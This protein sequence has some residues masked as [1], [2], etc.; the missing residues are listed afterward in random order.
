MEARGDVSRVIHS[1][2]T[3]KAFERRPISGLPVWLRPD[4]ALARVGPRTLA[5]GSGPEVEQLAQ[6]RLG[7][8]PDLKTAG[9]LF[10]RFQALN[11]ASAIRLV[12]RDPSKL[13]GLFHPIFTRELL[14]ASRIAW[15]VAQSSE[16]SQGAS[17]PQDEISAGGYGD[18]RAD[19]ERTAALAS[20]AGF[21]SPPLY[22]GAGSRG[23]RAPISSCASMFRRRALRLLLQRIAKADA[24]AR[25]GSEL[26]QAP[27]DLLTTLFV[28]IR[29]L[30]RQTIRGA[31]VLTFFSSI[32][33][34]AAEV[35]AGSDSEFVDI[36]SV[37]PTILVE[38]RY[39]TPNNFTRR[40]LYRADMP[41]MV[42]LSVAR[43]LAVA[44]KFLE[45]R[46]YGLKIWDAYRPKA[47]QDTTLEGNRQ[48]R[49]CGRP[50]R[51]HRVDAHPR[52]S[53]GRDAGGS[54]RAE[55]FP[56]RLNSIISRRPR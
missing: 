49:L 19:S 47:A 5:V 41:A 11:Q 35:A 42:R 22:P 37:D 51:R 38:L 9:Q 40:P 33:A 17:V 4:F 6:V 18:G 20:A 48:P 16:P 29:S 10:D 25:D 36:K 54:D 32:G 23:A 2:E 8:K 14:D 24:A 34:D 52:R 3:D 12:S 30:L 56:C 1:I 53:G 44:Q 15:F 28:N 39:A 43:R 55:K 31:L 50:Q 7:I 26:I 46:G 13:A 45:K 27:R 21:R